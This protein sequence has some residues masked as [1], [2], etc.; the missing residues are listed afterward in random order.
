MNLDGKKLT[1][2]PPVIPAVIEILNKT[3]GGKNI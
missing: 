3:G 2:F 1:L